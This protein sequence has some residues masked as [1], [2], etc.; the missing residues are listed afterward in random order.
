M[1]PAL[2]LGL[3]LVAGDP[4]AMPADDARDVDV[5]R[6]YDAARKATPRDADAQVALAL[7]CERNGLTAERLEHLARAVQANPAHA[8]ARALL[9]QVRVGEHWVRAG[10]SAESDAAQAAALAEYNGLRAKAAM[11]ADAQWELAVWCEQHGLQPEARAHLTA[12]VRL[13]PNR[14]AAWKRLG[15]KKMHGGWWTDEQLA[16]ARAAREAQQ[17]ANR[18]WMP[19]LKKW[20]ADLGDPRRRAIAEKALAGIS[21]PL[22]APAIW[23]TFALGN[24]DDQRRAVQLLGQL[25]APHATYGLA[26]LAVNTPTDEIGRAAVE[27]IA[28][29]DARGVIDPLIDLVRQPVRYE[30]RQGSRQGSTVDYELVVESDDEIHVRTYEGQ[31]LAAPPP[32]LF[33]EDMPFDPRFGQFSPLYG[34]GLTG[35]GYVLASQRDAEIARVVSRNDERMQRDF[36]RVQADIQRIDA[37]N[38]RATFQKERAL[39]ALRGLTGQD[40]GEDREGWRKWWADEQGITYRSPQE[41]PKRITTSLVSAESLHSCFAAGTP[42]HTK[43]GPKPIETLQVGDQVLALDV[44]SGALDF[45]PIVAAYHNPPNE[46]LRIRL[47]AETIVATPIHRFWVAGRGWVMARDLKAGDSVRLLNGVAT[48]SAVERDTVQPVFNLEVAS[49]HTFFVGD[50]GTLVHDNSPVLPVP[51]PF[52]ALADSLAATP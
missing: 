9:G 1:L 50:A 41:K 39:L 15:Y 7:W 34:I 19:R 36:Q 49:G 8:V 11:T 13:D 35:N 28:R 43:L 16:E 6:A 33:A 18:A 17:R 29:R 47:D 31:Q 5:R 38:A 21:D 45:Q 12:V 20:K 24:A 51:R 27:T 10:D 30:L 52:D 46:T 37:I 23:Q 14:D 25:D 32:R 44:R 26:T 42:V 22:A 40:F 4:G 48:V 3:G 2:L